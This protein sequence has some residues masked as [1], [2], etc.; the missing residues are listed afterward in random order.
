MGRGRRV[1]GVLLA[2]LLMSGCA[3]QVKTPV[4]ELDNR[5]HHYAQGMQALEDGRI[6]V[7]ERKFDQSVALAGH[8]SP[9]EGGQALIHAQAAAEEAMQL[10]T[11]D[12]SCNGPGIIMR[13]PR[14]SM[15]SIPRGCPT[16]LT[17]RRRITLWPR[18]SFRS[19]FARRN[20]C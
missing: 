8:F 11:P 18:R 3:A 1:W 4:S 16:I 2:G 19:I 20:R 12:H 10:Q 17:G 15:A 13:Q 6:G 14:M 7:A 5:W 9:A